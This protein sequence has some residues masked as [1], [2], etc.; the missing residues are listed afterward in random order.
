MGARHLSRR[1]AGALRT[2]GAASAAAPG[3]AS[4]CRLLPQPRED[5]GLKS[6]FVQKVDPRKDAHSN[7]I[8]KKETSSLSKLQFH[9]RCC[10]RFMKINITLVLWWGLGTRGMVSRIKLFTLGI[11]VIPYGKK[12][13]ASLKN[14]LLVEFNFWNEPIPQPGW[15]IYE[16]R[17]CQL[18]PGT[19]FQ[20]DRTV[21]RGGFVSHIGQLYMVHHLWACKALQTREDIRNAVWHKHGW[22]ELVYYTVPLMQ[23][24]ESR[25]MIPQKTCPSTEAT[26]WRCAYRSL[27][28]KCLSSINL[29]CVREKH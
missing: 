23:E 14:Q 28:D 18:Q 27:C 22:E 13:Q 24:M 2:R 16:L 21:T 15:N 8:I 4:P 12:Q 5:S 1:A 25:I 29:N 19:L 20:W 11:F 3:R 7:L 10:Q 9:N 6:L 17:S 26:E